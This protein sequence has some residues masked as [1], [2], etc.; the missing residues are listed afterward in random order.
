M[1]DAIASLPTAL[2]VVIFAIYFSAVMFATRYLVRRRSSPERQEELV[3]LADA[4]NG[5]TG[6]AMAFL[7]G[8][9]V[10]ITW[11]TI[12]SA[13][14]AIEKVAASA[15]EVAWLSENLSDRSKADAI[16]E[17]LK[18]YLTT[19][20]TED[21]A[22]LAERD[23]GELPSFTIADALEKQVRDV[24]ADA[25][26]GDPEASMALSAASAVAQ[27]QAEFVSIARRQLPASMLWLLLVTG[28]VSC[29]VMG[30]VATKIKRPWLLV[31]WALVSAV[32]IGV[33]LSLYNPFTGDVGVDLQPLSDAANRI[34]I[35]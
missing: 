31:G 21:A 24:A 34:L 18:E 23:L 2:I 7:I 26:E 29:V 3:T 22:Q 35:P 16:V 33:V 20:A 14:S 28:T 30:V 8:F 6:V 4:M 13:Q 19:I 11:G 27:N 15:Q 17:T 10:T 32:G 12:S 25:S 9:S 5:P 1:F